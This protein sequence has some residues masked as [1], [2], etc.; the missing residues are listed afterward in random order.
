MA[1]ASTLPISSIYYYLRNMKL[2][3]YSAF[4]LVF[5][6]CSNPDD[7]LPAVQSIVL[8]GQDSE[9]HGLAGIIHEISVQ[10]TD[11]KE[12]NQLKISVV[13]NSASH[14]HA[15]EPISAF[16]SP[17]IGNWDTLCIFSASGQQA[18]STVYFQAPDDIAGMW[19]VVAQVL[20]A[21]GNLKQ[22]KMDLHIQN[23]LIPAIQIQSTTPAAVENGI[24]NL[25]LTGSGWLG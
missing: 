7:E 1:I 17:N 20:D 3:F 16:I 24:I 12:L 13:P 14:G 5:I 18:A 11:N 4:L 23:D 22:E 9:F 19:S 10:A 8:N 15:D 2:L 25:P 21:N 6:A